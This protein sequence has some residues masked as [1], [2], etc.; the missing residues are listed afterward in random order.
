MRIAMVAS[1]HKVDDDRITHKQAFSLA[2]TGHQVAVFGLKPIIPPSHSGVEFHVLEPSGSGLRRRL[3]MLKLLY[4]RVVAWCPDVV[5][6]HEPDSAV[7]GLR[8]RRKTGAKVVFDTHE[9][10]EETFAERVPPLMRPPVRWAV[11]QALRFFGRRYDWVTVVSPVNWDFYAMFRSTS[12]MSIIH[13]SPRMELFPPCTHEVQGP[14]TLVHDG[15]LYRNRGMVE[16]LEALAIVRKSIDVRLLVV[17][18]VLSEE[19]PLFD[20]KVEELDL[21]EIIEI[22]G[23]RPYEEVGLLESKGQIGLIALQPRPNAMKS[24]N[25]KFY[26]YMSCAQPVIAPIDSATE[27]MVRK[28]DCGICIDT[29]Q[30]KQIAEAVL[31]LAQDTE[32]RKHY[33]AKGRRAIEEELGWHMMEKELARIYAAL[34]PSAGE[35]DR[36]RILCSTENA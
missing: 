20:Q 11:R 24:L 34:A 36:Q 21:K 32:L 9:S 30:P 14:L 8:I 33:G 26:N 3:S 28:Y 16:I 27:M 4:D 29:T 7:L 25:H 13:N 18:C 17:G 35:L 15:Y 6:C 22:P 31:K 19:R 5:T 12:T 23:W 1:S 2:N 10:F